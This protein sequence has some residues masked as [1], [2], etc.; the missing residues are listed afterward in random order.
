MPLINLEYL[1]IG[2]DVVLTVTGLLD[3]LTDEYFN[4]ATVNVTVKDLSGTN[5]S[6]QTWPLALNYIVASDGDYEG[7][8]E[9]GM[10]LTDGRYYEIAVTTNVGADL[11]ALWRKRLPARYREWES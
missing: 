8:L 9:D 11:V 6:G 5:V 1:P 2:N 10:V 4:G 7:V 3:P